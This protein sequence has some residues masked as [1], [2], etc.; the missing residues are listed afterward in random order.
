MHHE[1]TALTERVVPLREVR[2]NLYS[3]TEAAEYFHVTVT[4]IHNWIK[5][6]YLHA[7]RMN[8]PRGKWYI[9]QQEI[10]YIERDFIQVASNESV[11]RIMPRVLY[12]V[13]NNLRVR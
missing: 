7:T 8:E 1:H 6:G 10:E 5:K 9:T 11:R 3:T 4:T 2:M 13:K 12:Q